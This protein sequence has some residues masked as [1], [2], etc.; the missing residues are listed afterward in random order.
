MKKG[1]ALLIT[2]IFVMLITVSVG[3][4]LTQIENTSK[5]IQKQNFL[6]QTVMILN[7][8]EN[9]LKNSKELDLIIKDNSAESLNMFL[10]TASFIP[11]ESSGIKVLIE[12]SSARAKF[13]PNMLQDN[14][15]TLMQLK[16]DRL[17]RFFEQKNINMEYTDILLDNMSK[18]KEDMSYNSDIF[19]SNPDLF[20]DYIVSF[21][22]LDKINEFYS[23]KY[24]ED[25]SKKIDFKKL[26]YFTKAD[27][28]KIDLNYISADIWQLLT[29][30]DD[31]K[32]QTLAQNAGAYTKVDEL[33]LS[34][35]EIE[36]LNLFN[37]SFFEPIIYVNLEIIKDNLDAKISFEYNLK[38]KKG[39][40]FIYE[41]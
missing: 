28:Y 38:T 19:N 4:G 40:N 8:V 5:S 1:I 25:I 2:L 31:L 37:Y 9:I 3:I 7:D 23:Q 6:F 13:N 29:G 10:S 34:G 20:R 11:F 18:I 15:S 21:E 35:E 17:K 36:S 39:T 27:N 26:F 30:C 33:G 24:H 32:S 14:N 12:L 22:H 16:T 41:L